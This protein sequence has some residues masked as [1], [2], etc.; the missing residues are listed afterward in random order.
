MHTTE[1]LFREV[2][3]V[4]KTTATQFQK[5]FGGDVDDYFS[6][7]QLLFLQASGRYDETRGA[8]FTT[9][10]RKVL[11]NR[12]HSRRKYE[13]RRHPPVNS[14]RVPED[15][16]PCHRKRLPR[17]VWG[18]TVSDS[19]LTVIDLVTWPPPDI[20]PELRAHRHKPR[21]YRR[22]ITRLLRD[23][24]WSVE[25]IRAAFE[26]IADALRDSP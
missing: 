10:F 14:E 18:G 4:I 24:G 19:A 7:G 13:L 1:R 16:L 9:W 3:S 26:E 22:L 17:R 20:A 2:E 6:D 23:L 25:E 8:S 12:F 21:T 11:W 5:R 15:T